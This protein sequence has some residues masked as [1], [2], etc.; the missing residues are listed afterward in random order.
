MIQQQA[1]VS[2]AEALDRANLLKGLYLCTKNSLALGSGEITPLILEA[3][4]EEE[5][6]QKMALLFP[7]ETAQG[8]TIQLINPLNL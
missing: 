5:A 1:P 6:W 4:T 8:F 7:S 3:N 2:L